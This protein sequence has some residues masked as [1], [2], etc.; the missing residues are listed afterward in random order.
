MRRGY[1]TVDVD[2]VEVCWSDIIGE[3]PDNE[4]LAE[5]A[6]RKLLQVDPIAGD[7]EDLETVLEMLDHG[8]YDEAAL[9][10]DRL[11]H[12][13]Y[14]TFEQAMGAFVAAKGK[15]PKP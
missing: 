4:L 5:V 13:K 7:P 11:L 2:P 1:I 3:L 15:S 12:P 9:L 8:N 6:R 10:L 14:A